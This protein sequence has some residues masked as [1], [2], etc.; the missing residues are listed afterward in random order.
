MYNSHTMS[1]KIWN[2]AMPALLAVFAVLTM[3]AVVPSLAWAQEPASEPSIE[4]VIR[5]FSEKEKEF[6]IARENYTFRQEVLVQDLGPSNRL[7]GEFRETTEISFDEKGRRSERV[8]HAP[9]NTL[10][11]FFM[12]PEDMQSFESIQPFVLTSD[13]IGQ[14]NLK[15][16]GKEKVDEITAYVFE[17]SPKKIEKNKRYFEGKIWVDDRDFQIVK[18]F[19]KSVPDIRN[20]KN[21]NIFPKF[22]TY[23]EQIDGQYWFPTY[24]RAVDILDFTREKIHYRSIVKY[25]DYK[26]FQTSVKLR[27]GGEVTDDKAAPATDADKEKLAPALD[28]KYKKEPPKTDKK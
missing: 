15:Y 1:T 14:Y 18:T 5:K 25:T 19:G 28:P 17:V 16:G 11:N 27:F 23:R 4:E 26:K 6:K 3:A 22:E 12:S 7:V 21:E 24:T 13:D 10:K 20:G 8:V 2:F 9:P